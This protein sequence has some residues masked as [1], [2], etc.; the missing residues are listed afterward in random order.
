MDG[1]PGHE[2]Q[3]A[4]LVAA[5]AQTGGV[6]CWNISVGSRKNPWLWWFAGQFPPGQGLPDPDLIMGAGHAT[7][8]AL[9]AAR[10]AR[11]GKGVVLMMP[12]LP[13]F[14]FDLCLI[15]EH[16]D[17]P[18]RNNVEPTRGVL[19]PLSDQGRHREDRGVILIGGPSPH[20]AW[21]SME[22]SRQV[23]KLVGESPG[24]NWRLTTSRRTPGD[25]L[26]ALPPQTGLECIPAEATP[27]GWVESQLAEAG[28]AW[29]TP[30]SVSMVYEALSAGCRV[31]LLDL[32]ARAESRVAAGVN[33][34]LEEGWVIT[35]G[36][37][38]LPPPPGAVLNEAARCASLIRERWFPWDA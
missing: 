21:D 31:G 10:R 32:P 7:H 25:F 13:L 34:L 27:P 14:L 38:R 2:K 8:M 9:L 3:T 18:H 16:D 19:N 11:G 30:D 6:D 20:F 5:L 33:R 4:G 36:R 1:K 12:S 17:P 35:Q 37:R 29:C 28:E 24:M 26:A 15:P 23:V 22:V